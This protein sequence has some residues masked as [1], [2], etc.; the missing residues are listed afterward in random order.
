MPDPLTNSALRVN[1]RQNIWD[2]GRTITGKKAAGLGIEA[3][4]QTRN[5][6]VQQVAFGAQAAFWNVVVAKEMLLVARDAEKAAQANVDLAGEL[7]DA[8]LAV[9][10]DR[11]SAE[12]RLSEVQALRI[13]A[14]QGVEV[15]HAALRQA[16]GV[17]EDR[18]LT[19]RAPDETPG[20][21]IDS[22]DARID[23]ALRSR[24]DLLA[25]ER[26]VEQARLG[27]KIARSRRRPE[28]GAMAGY[29]WNGENFLGTDGDNWTIGLGLK[30]SVFDGTETRARVGVATART[31][32]ASAMAESMRQG[33]R[34]EVRSA[35]ADREAA[36]QRLAVA[37]TALERAAE[38]LRI[39][40]DRYGEGMAV[41]V[42][43]LAAEAAHTR[44][45]ANHVAARGDVWL[46]HAA[47]DLATGRT[48]WKN[49]DADGNA[50]GETAA[51]TDRR[52]TDD[53]IR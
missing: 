1:V 47:L 51:R 19:V 16:L 12:V 13:R 33:I 39:V 7:V 4:E 22:L 11:L 24:P 10:S 48:T 25:V 21:W 29:E 2:A 36:E 49:A 6:T 20:G 26:R 5:R 31:A 45:R 30:L 43:L 44:A 34:L 23:E 42:E 15:A 3:A 38:S 52:G 27:E 53:E 9:S 50:P 8:G 17:G 18:D 40:R 41:M 28:I 46:A 32:E 37:A 35:W 14:E